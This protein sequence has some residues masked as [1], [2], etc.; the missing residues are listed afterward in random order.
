MTGL[1][2]L[3]TIAV[4]DQSTPIETEHSANTVH[5]S[6]IRDGFDL[7]GVKVAFPHPLLIDDHTPDAETA[8]LHNLAGSDRAIAEFTRDSVTAPLILKIRDIAVENKGTIRAAD[9]WFVVY[10][11]LEALD[12][13]KAS[14]SEDGKPFEAGNMRFGVTRIGEKEL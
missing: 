6:L 14:G 10:T 5:T 8:I 9:L 2:F 4:S 13:D 11:N 7:A 12:L 1:L 3:L